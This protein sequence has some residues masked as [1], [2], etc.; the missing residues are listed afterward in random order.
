MQ[1]GIKTVSS[2]VVSQL[3]MLVQLLSPASDGIY[4]VAIGCF[5][6]NRIRMLGR[7][8]YCITGMNNK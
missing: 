8:S 7:L 2:T 1:G 6:L 4:N 3:L 5:N